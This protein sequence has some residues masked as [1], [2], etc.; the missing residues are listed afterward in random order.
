MAN[1]IIVK[2]FL[3]T[4]LESYSSQGI[5]FV[6]SIFMARILAPADYGIIGIIGVFLALSDIFID[7]GFS[8]ALINKQNCTKT[9]YST[10]FYTNIVISMALFAILYFCAPLIASFYKNPVLVWTTRAMALTFVISSFG[11]VSMT[12]LTKELR[13]KAKAIITF[14]VSCVSGFIGIYL[15]YSG[16]GVWALVWQSV[17]SCAIRVVVSVIYVRWKPILK[18][19]RHSFVELFRFGS[20]LLGSNIIYTLYNNIYSLVIGKVFNPTQ[21]GYFSRAEG[22]AKLIPI[23]VSGVLAKILFP[24]LSKAQNNEEE[25]IRLYHKFILITSAILFP[26]CLFIVGLAAPLVSLLITDKWMPIVPLLQILS[27]SGIFE[28]FT[29]INSNFI[30]AKGKSNLFLQMHLRTKIIGILILLVSVIFNLTVVA[31][32]KV[33]YSLV[34]VLVSYYYFC[35]IFA[36]KLNKDLSNLLKIFILSGGIAIADIMIFNQ[37]SYTWLSLVGVLMVS[38]IVYT[39]GL[40]F[41]CPHV[42]EMLK[43]VY[44]SK[45]INK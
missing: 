26:G 34:C 20:N 25:M 5:A 42:L 8:N 36:V 28:H 14:V 7:S 40:H 13:F 9:D 30:L 24:I 1:K 27:F 12:I 10:V 29:S 4:A 32:G 3:W 39:L 41:L 16:W 33:L 45:N 2:S 11:A 19:S 22:Y 44:K 23:N 17:I 43:Q 15:A 38:C 21:L 37:I 35:K 6:V 18:F 31:W